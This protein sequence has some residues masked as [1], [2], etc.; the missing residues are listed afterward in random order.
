MRLFIL[1]CFTLLVFTLSVSRPAQARETQT[2]YLRYS[3]STQV[4]RALKLPVGLTRV[5]AD[6][7][8]NAL[9]VDGSPEAID[10]VRQLVTTLDVKIPQILFVAQVLR[11]DFAPD[12]TW[13]MTEVS[14]PRI[15]TLNDFRVSAEIKS[16]NA[17]DG[18]MIQTTLSIVP[19]LNP[20]GTID[21]DGTMTHTEFAGK[22]GRATDLSFRRTLAPDKRA[23]FGLADSADTDVQKEVSAGRFPTHLKAPVSV[24]YL[25]FSASVVKQR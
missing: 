24:Y 4:V 12:G 21:C 16:T 13:E 5:T 17:Q 10:T 20:D 9:I 3:S 25:K 1:S 18:T 14:A 22:T 23:T 15:T 8:Q 11:F 2:I 7:K 6:A 19:H